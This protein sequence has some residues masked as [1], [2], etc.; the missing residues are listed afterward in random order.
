MDLAIAIL[1][2]VFSGSKSTLAPAAWARTDVVLESSVL[3]GA[4]TESA[5]RSF[6]KAE[7][8]QPPPCIGN[9]CQP[10]VSIPVPGFEPQI[11]MRG[12][13]GEVFA[14]MLERLDAG[15]V[16]NIARAAATA[17][18]R[19]EYRPPRAQD[20]L[21]GSRNLGQVA[22]MARWRLDAWNVPM[23]QVSPSP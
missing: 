14:S 16:A 15:V 2:L 1:L 21:P 8:W 13:G 11:D 17:G 19:L 4:L 22:I 10:R 18:V 7:P 9:T 3:D 20:L 23:F 12:R 6:G 5:L